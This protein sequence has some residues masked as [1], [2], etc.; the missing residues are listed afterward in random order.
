MENKLSKG[1]KKIIFL[2]PNIIGIYEKPATPHVGMAYLA[3]VAREKHDV[4]II[5][6]RVK[7]DLDKVI[8]EMDYYHPD[9][10][11]VHS[12][13]YQH[14]KSYDLVATLKK[15]FPKSTLIIGGPHAST[16]L[17]K[18]LKETKADL[19]VFGEGEK[20][21]L[22]LL[23]GKTYDKIDGVIWRDGKKVVINSP[24]KFIEDLDTIPF[25]AYDLYDL[26]KYLDKKIPIVSSRGCPSA[27]TYCSIKMIFGKPFRPRSAKNVIDEIKFWYKK[28]YKFFQFTDDCFTFDVD[29]A[30]KICQMLIKSKIK[31]EWELRNGIRID[32][33]DYELL[34]LMKKS[35]CKVIAYGIESGVQEVLKQMKKGILVKKVREV[36]INTK[37]VGIKTVGFFMIGT[38]GDTFE[39]FKKTFEF[40]KSLPLDEVRFYSTIPYPQT[41][42]FDWVLKNG[43]WLNKPEEYLNTS[44]AWDDS[45][46]FETKDF[47][48]KE[49]KMALDMSRDLVMNKFL[50]SQFGKVV[51]NFGFILW[52]N[53]IFRKI[54]TKPGIWLLSILRRLRIAT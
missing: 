28:G 51:G 3:G 47:T 7:K 23:D 33:V 50:T 11:C 10:I 6:M 35:G 19:A 18:I 39:N 42:L 9:L 20:T 54:A 43:K 2:I 44:N 14:K 49:R 21:F 15:K 37:K 4:K 48:K 40:A 52:K 53:K 24:R 8:K 27:C 12:C 31:I 45:P 29:R 30:K 41:E 1:K 36:I 38:P 26:S 17:E 5:D 32:R 16:W 46:V 25:P 34:V 22:E 13:T